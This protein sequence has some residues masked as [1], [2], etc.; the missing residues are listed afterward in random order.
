MVFSPQMKGGFAPENRAYQ[1]LCQEV[2][3]IC[4]IN[5]VETR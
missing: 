1:A 3:L 4:A 5:P 2:R